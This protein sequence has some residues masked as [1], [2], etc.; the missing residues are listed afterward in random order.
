MLN[1]VAAAAET[2]T[3]TRAAMLVAACSYSDVCQGKKEDE[4]VYLA[5]L[6]VIRANEKARDAAQWAHINALIALAAAEDAARAA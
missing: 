3:A 2:V 5:R 4:T 6:A 1:A